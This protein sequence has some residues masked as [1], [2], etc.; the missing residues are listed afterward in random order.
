MRLRNWEKGQVSRT[1]PKYCAESSVYYIKLLC[2]S[3]RNW[4]KGQVSRAFP[5]YCAESSVYYIK[6][7]CMS[8]RNWE[9]GEVSR[10]FPKY[11]CESSVMF[12][13][14]LICHSPDM[15]STKK[16]PSWSWSYGSWICNYLCNQCL[17]LW[18]RIPIMARCTRYNIMW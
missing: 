17:S 2:M 3:L 6:L 10:T 13:I 11:C 7:L 4:A 5:K 16:G 8:L 14:L 1:F 18:V 15:S 12:Y 9:K